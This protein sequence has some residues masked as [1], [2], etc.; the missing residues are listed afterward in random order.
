MVED[1]VLPEERIENRRAIPGRV[2]RL[3]VRPAKLIR[4][5]RLLRRDRRPAQELAVWRRAD[6]RHR[7]IA[8]QRRLIV[9]H[10]PLHAPVPF[11]SQ[12]HTVRT[13]RHPPLLEKPR[14]PFPR[15][16]A[17]ELRPRMFAAN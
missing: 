4:Q 12:R 15:R 5:N 6:R 9:Q 11:E 16:L 17:R 2:N 8:R 14:H 10:D 7:E 3:D 1:A 13:H